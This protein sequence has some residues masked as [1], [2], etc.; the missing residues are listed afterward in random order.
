VALLT[1]REQELE[2]ERSKD[3]QEM[4]TLRAGTQQKKGV[5]SNGKSYQ[6]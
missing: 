3:M 2:Q 5:T 6:N 4:M 1:E